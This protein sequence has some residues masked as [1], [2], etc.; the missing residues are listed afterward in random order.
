MEIVNLNPRP[1]ENPETLATELQGTARIVKMGDKVLSYTNGKGE[2]KNYRLATIAYKANGASAVQ[3]AQVSEK[4]YTNDDLKQ[5]DIVSVN[6]SADEN[7][8]YF[9]VIGT[10]GGS[11]IQ[12]RETFESLMGAVKNAKSIAKATIAETAPAMGGESTGE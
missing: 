10:G 8:T 5:G 12:S 7:D 4:T 3:S 1:V 9:R 2:E 6:I 11:G